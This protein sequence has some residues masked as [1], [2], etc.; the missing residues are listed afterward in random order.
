[1]PPA[2]IRI[3]GCLSLAFVLGCADTLTGRSRPEQFY[4]RWQ[5]IGDGLPSV[6]VEVRPGSD[7]AVG[8]VSLSGVTSTLP[9]VVSKAKL[10]FGAL[11]SSAPAPYWAVL[12][13]STV[14]RFSI[15]G[16]WQP[17]SD[18][19]DPSVDVLLRKVH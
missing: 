1:M 19:P 15:R 18:K 4:G 17:G 2:A 12:E 6:M 9:V 5:A 7:G 3:V 8:Q 14:L 11:N 16:T 10:V 13:T